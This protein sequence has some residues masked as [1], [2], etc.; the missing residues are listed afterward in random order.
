MKKISLF[1]LALLLSGA[2][3]GQLNPVKWTYESRKA[4][5]GE[6][7]LVFT[8]HIQEGWYVYSQ[9]LESDEGPVRTT[10]TF[11]E[12][13]QVELVGNCKEDGH[14]YEGFDEL[15]YMN[16]IKFSGEPMFTQ[17]VKIKAPTTLTGHLEFM[18]CDNEKCLPPK[19]VEFRFGLE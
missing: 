13:S 10:F 17:R 14:K 9:F 7:D 12:N 5:D 16:I 3:F 4:G 19:E 2:V 8:A 1:T 15:F 11:D 18:T 6:Y